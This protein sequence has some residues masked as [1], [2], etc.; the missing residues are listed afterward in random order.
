MPVPIIYADIEPEFVEIDYLEEFIQDDFIKLSEEEQEERIGRE[1]L[2]MMGRL[3]VTHKP[4]VCQQLISNPDDYRW[5]LVA[6]PG[7]V[8]GVSGGIED[9]TVVALLS[10]SPLESD[11]PDV[12]YVVLPAGA[13]KQDSKGEPQLVQQGDYLMVFRIFEGMKSMTDQQGATASIPAIYAS[14]IPFSNQ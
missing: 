14:A 2:S 12:F 10:G 13:L 9:R 6:V 1:R 4:L 11:N 7:R 3:M 8:L 5:T